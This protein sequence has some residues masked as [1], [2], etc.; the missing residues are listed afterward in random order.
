MGGHG[1]G[2]ESW[3]LVEG[4]GGKERGSLPKG[5]TQRRVGLHDVLAHEVVQLAF[6]TMK[7][8]DWCQRKEK[9][10]RKLTARRYDFSPTRSRYRRQNG[11]VP[12]C[13]LIVLRSFLELTIL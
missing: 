3:K 6:D 7:V 12:N 13:L 5:V 2:L 8:S 4:N 9:E 11:S 1:S 10:S